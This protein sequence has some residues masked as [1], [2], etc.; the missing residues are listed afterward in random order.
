MVI[1]NLLH[2][3]LRKKKH[4][5]PKMNEHHEFLL[6]LFNMIP[7]YK[8]LYSM[9][10]CDLREILTTLNDQIKDKIIQDFDDNVSKP[11]DYKGMFQVDSEESD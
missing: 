9:N 3:F 5:F 7:G 10:P 4:F 6:L 1:G 2:K 11:R 8:V